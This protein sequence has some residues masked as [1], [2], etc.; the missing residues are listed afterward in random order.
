[1]ADFEALIK[2]HV[3][4]N[5]Q[6]PASAIGNIVDSIKKTVGDEFV[7]KERYKTK[8]SELDSLKTKLQDAED[9]V[10]TA[11]KWKTKYEETEKAFSDFK[12]KQT[13][14]ATK[15]AKDKA[16]RALLKEIGLSSKYH[17]R[18]MKG[19]SYNELSLDENGNLVD[20]D[21]ITASI[22][23]EWGDCIGKE[24]SKGADTATPPNNT[25]GKAMTKEEIM[26]I[27][28]K[29]ERHKMMKEHH[30]LFGIE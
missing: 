6:I 22:K 12:E 7:S 20:S 1:M 29:S 28:N 27:E 21:K 10:T 30:E 25:G 16:Y 24:S 15:T 17:D 19:I 18:A 5:G 13:E 2:K 9:N 3:D 26:A 14:E 11:E 4:E 23:K 8:L